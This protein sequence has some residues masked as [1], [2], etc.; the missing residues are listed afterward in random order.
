MKL[1]IGRGACGGGEFL[2]CRVARLVSSRLV[3]VRERVAEPVTEVCRA[4]VLLLE[5]WVFDDGSPNGTVLVV[6]SFECT[7]L[8][9]REWATLLATRLLKDGCSIW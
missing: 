5:Y 7:V 4:A 9:L 3:E 8:L 2:L 1:L 6:P